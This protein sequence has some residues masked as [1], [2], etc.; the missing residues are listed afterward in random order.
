MRSMSCIPT[1][2]IMS[3][4]VTAF[5]RMDSSEVIAQALDSDWPFCV[6]MLLA[7]AIPCRVRVLFGAC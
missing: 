5:S 6:V 4:S 3:R 7:F 2:S 1:V